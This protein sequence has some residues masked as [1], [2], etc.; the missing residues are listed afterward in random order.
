[1][2][3]C[4]GLTVVLR[5]PSEISNETKLQIQSIHGTYSSR[6]AGTHARDKQYWDSWVWRQLASDGFDSKVT[7][8]LLS[9]PG[10][11]V[12]GYA[13]GH[14][15]G[16]EMQIDEFGSDDEEMKLDGGQMCFERASRALFNHKKPLNAQR[17]NAERKTQTLTLRVP[18]AV[19]ALF[20]NSSSLSGKWTLSRYVDRGYMY[21]AVGGSAVGHEAVEKLVCG[22]FVCS[23]FM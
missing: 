4:A 18:I 8:A 3:S 7:C 19:R 5:K 16:C 12:C 13:M 23:T 17:D 11:G 9:R 6:L 14:W 20:K 22:L 15:D 2:N 21:R 1:M 10:K